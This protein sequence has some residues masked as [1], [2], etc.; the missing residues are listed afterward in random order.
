MRIELE[1]ELIP[2]S[3]IVQGF[4]GIL[5]LDPLTMGNEGKMI[6]AVS[7]KDAEKAVNILKRNKY[8]RNA[9]AAGQV[10]E[11]KGVYLRTALGVLR[12][13]LPL[14]GEGLPRIC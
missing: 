1:E 11:G 4:T 8:G 6:I 14:R 13:V 9:V 3:D 2:V 12:R 10:M 5:G 7:P